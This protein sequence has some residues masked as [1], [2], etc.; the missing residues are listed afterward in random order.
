MCFEKMMSK[1]FIAFL[2]PIGILPI[3]HF[4]FAYKIHLKSVEKNY[5]TTKYIPE[6]K[7]T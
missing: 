7:F 5:S 2:L 4:E 1:K 6:F 3:K